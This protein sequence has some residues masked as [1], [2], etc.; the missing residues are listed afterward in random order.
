MIMRGKKVWG[1]KSVV[2]HAYQKGGASARKC[3]L[4]SEMWL[5]TRSH[6]DPHGVR[7]EKPGISSRGPTG[8]TDRGGEMKLQCKK[9]AHGEVF[10]SLEEEKNGEE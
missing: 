3:P 8:R 1:G 4:S 2:N 10:F 9:N 5:G 6:G 7:G